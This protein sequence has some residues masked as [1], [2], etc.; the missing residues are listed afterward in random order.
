MYTNKQVTKTAVADDLAPPLSTPLG[1]R[2]VG[3]GSRGGTC[4]CMWLAEQ[5]TLQMKA[6]N[7]AAFIHFTHKSH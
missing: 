2:K 6:G 3:A 5:M 7:V 4:V 1:L